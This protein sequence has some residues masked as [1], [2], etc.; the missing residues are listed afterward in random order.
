R[1]QRNLGPRHRERA[2]ITLRG[3]ESRGALAERTT[4][5]PG[6][7]GAPQARQVLR[8]ATRAPAPVTWGASRYSDGHGPGRPQETVAP[9]LRTV[10]RGGRQRRRARPE[11]PG[12][13]RP[14]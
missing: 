13:R 1:P 2:G 6:G 9:P 12:R 10:G 14:G 4:D 3:R 7:L 5:G 8:S 11:L